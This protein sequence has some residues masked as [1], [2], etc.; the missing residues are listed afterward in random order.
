MKKTV[1]A[2][3]AIALSGVLFPSASASAAAAGPLKVLT[4][5]GTAICPKGSVCL[6]A[7]PDYNAGHPKGLIWAVSGSVPKLSTYKNPDNNAASLY[8]RTSSKYFVMAYE[9]ENYR[10]DYI[11]LGGTPIRD[12]RKNRDV[13]SEGTNDHPHKRPF[14][15]VISSVRF[16]EVEVTS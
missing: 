11:P 5:E 9:D 15:N 2:A 14:A 4:G 6:Y 10:G 1:A 16:A 8:V 3:I 13:Y 7:Y 12:L